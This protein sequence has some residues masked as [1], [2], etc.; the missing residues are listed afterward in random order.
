[1]RQ[2]VYFIL[3][4]RTL[5]LDVSGP[6]EALW[7]ANRY[8]SAVRFE[9]HYA[10]PSERVE[11]SIGLALSGL[12]ELPDSLPRN[13]MIVIAGSAPPGSED[14]NS[15]QTIVAWLRRVARPTH[16]LV[17]ICSGALL[18]ARAG[19]LD[20]RSC[21]T[22]HSD[23]GELRRLAPTAKVLD[24]R[25]YVC[26]G[27]V[28]TSAGVTAGIDLM[29]HLIGE[30]AGPL[31]AV[32]VARNMVVY[33]RRTGADP[34]LS[35]WLESRNHMHPVVHRVQD[36]IAADPAHPWTLDELAAIAH[37]SPRHLDRLFQIHTGTRPL[38][39]VNALRVALAR[40]LLANSQLT[41]DH[42]AERAGFGSSRHLRR[43]WRQYDATSPGRWRRR[44]PR[45][46]EAGSA[47]Y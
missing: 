11:S 41:L 29:L 33:L 27:N 26:D 14:E 18:A 24:N 19:V 38:A 43:I 3:P 36:A 9:L 44:D 16:R 34:Q 22:H 13:A 45:A 1:M 28:S 17:F 12:A 47:D 25:I 42:V 10:S 2:P 40:Q 37:A 4:P 23:C 46:R 39:Y 5:L 8:Q 31:C 6:A 21:T 32:A 7:M 30:I 35:P 20:G 15:Q